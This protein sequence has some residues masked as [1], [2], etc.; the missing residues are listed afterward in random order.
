MMRSLWFYL[1]SDGR[2]P[3]PCSSEYWRAW[4]RDRPDETRVAKTKRGDSWV[5]TIFLGYAIVDNDAGTVD[6]GQLPLW[7]TYAWIGSQR[8]FEDDDPVRWTSRAAAEA[9]HAIVCLRVF[10]DAVNAKPVPPPRRAMK[11]E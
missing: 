2:T 5:S 3:V 6:V 8:A 4:R 7:E 1:D 9:G 11:L 10:G